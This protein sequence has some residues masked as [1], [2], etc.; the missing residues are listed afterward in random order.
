MD[1]FDDMIP[2]ARAGFFLKKMK[3]AFLVS[4]TFTAF[5]FLIASCTS[6][7]Q[8]FNPTQTEYNWQEVQPGIW[9]FDYK[10]S[11]FPVIYHAVKIDLTTPGLEITCFPQT[12]NQN[13]KAKRITTARFASKYNTTVAIN[14]TPFSKEDIVGVHIND[15][16]LISRPVPGYAVIAFSKDSLGWQA[17]IFD[18]QTDE[19]LQNYDYAFGGFFTVLKNSSPYG[20]Y[21][22]ITDSRMGVGI[23]QD[24]RTLIIL[25]VE[26]EI[27]FISRGL[28]YEQCAQI[29]LEMGCTH[30]LE[31][32]GGGS[33]QLCIN[34]KS[35]LTYPA[36]RKQGNSFGFYTK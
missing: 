24:G 2:L 26:G 13:T 34:G 15:G 31:L 8:E 14:A 10:D 1:P 28:S 16:Q 6:T 29:F 4:L 32:D 3:K 18:S 11:S 21:L 33:T 5:L 12:Q 22:P 7:K 35:V 36:F 30:A 27:H 23:T 25:A 20:T 19:L 17:F 9:R